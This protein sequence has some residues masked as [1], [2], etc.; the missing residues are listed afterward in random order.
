MGKYSAEK[1]VQILIA[2][3]KANHIRK[4]IVSP[5]TTH[6]SFIV[7][8]VNDGGFELYSAVDERGAAYIACGLASESG[9]PVVITCTGA[10]ASRN[11]F[12]GLTEAY[13][14]KL[15][16]LA[17]TASQDFIRAGNL[18]PQYIDRTEQPTDSVRMSVQVPI[19]RSKEDE[20]DATLKINRAVL[21]LFHRGG[22]PVHINLASSYN[23]DFSVEE[24][25]RV[26][27]MR[28]FTWGQTLP[29]IS[30]NSRI[31]ITVG[32]HKTFSPELTAAVDAFCGLY[33]AVVIVDHSSHY[34]GKYRVLPAILTAQERH[35]SSLFDVDLLIHIGEE[36]GDY[37]TN[38]KL[39]QAREVWRVSEDGEIRDTFGKLTN[40]FEM[41]ELAFFRHYSENVRLPEP[42]HAFYDAFM[43]EIEG[44]EHTVPELPFSNIWIAQQSIP[45]FPAKAN[46]ELGVSNT[47]RAWTFFD[48]PE[49]NYVLANTGCR[50]IDG[51]VPTLLGMSLADQERLH[52]AVMGDLTFFYSFNVLGNRHF[53]SNVRLL[54][55]NNGCGA[56][57]N[58]YPN[59]GY[60][61]YNGNS[62]DINQFIGAGGHSGAKSP[63]LVRH[64]A[65]DLGFEYLTASTKE[66]YLAQLD[67][68]FAPELTD[69]PMLFEVFTEAANESDALWKICH[70]KED[71]APS[72]NSKLK[73]KLKQILG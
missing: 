31:A 17:V 55:I 11:Y 39:K 50:G 19:V 2:V 35:R 15:P 5:G 54:L 33:D 49:K 46:L 47:M 40:T 34:Y 53:G 62:Q 59:R 23:N 28:R 21:E 14:R 29:D 38:P 56:E 68:F 16:I 30:D 37:L 32:A 25:P 48:F 3:L 26:R 72:F 58:I 7:S 44:L 52:F 42:K 20:Y 60:K 70:I 27:I 1:N 8:L 10:T 41:T 69:K 45:R 18:S 61:Y 66:E 12:P 36:H 43:R 9:E 63:L 4:V 71:P 65:E 13:H 24:L 73:S 22:G 64:Y 57:F 51:A 6:I 67:R